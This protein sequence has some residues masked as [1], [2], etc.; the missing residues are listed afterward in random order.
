[1]EN[2]RQKNVNVQ[3]T[4]GK[5]CSVKLNFQKAVNCESI[6][7][8]S[9]TKTVRSI[10]IIV[11]V[12]ISQPLAIADV[13]PSRAVQP[14]PIVR[15]RSQLGEEL[16]RGRVDFRIVRKER[17]KTEGHTRSINGQNDRIVS[18]SWRRE[19]PRL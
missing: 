1:M 7:F 2:L 8:S 14:R 6:K 18:G 15:E 19:R 16:C 12:N 11:D 17:N 4:E 13:V 9:E 5:E 3:R 10:P